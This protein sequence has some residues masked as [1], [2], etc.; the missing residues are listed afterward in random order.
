MAPEARQSALVLPLLPRQVLSR[1]GDS[2]YVY[3]S[4]QVHTRVMEG[5]CQDVMAL[6]PSVCLL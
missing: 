3:Y 6:T 4:V 1:A 5:A 2:H